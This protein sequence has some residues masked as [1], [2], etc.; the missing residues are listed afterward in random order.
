[1]RELRKVKKGNETKKSKGS[2]E[3]RE[4]KDTYLFV[5]SSVVSLIL[6]MANIHSNQGNYVK[7]PRCDPEKII[8]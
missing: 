6:T 7:Q 3:K 8:I 4:T 2:C 1:M 5:C